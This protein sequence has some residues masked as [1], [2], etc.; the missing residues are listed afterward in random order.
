LNIYR[1]TTKQYGTVTEANIGNDV[2]NDNLVLSME[3]QSTSQVF[4]GGMNVYSNTGEATI[5]P[6]SGIYLGKKVNDTINY[7]TKSTAKG[8]LTEGIEYVAGAGYAS[9]TNYPRVRVVGQNRDTTDNTNAN[10]RQG[11]NGLDGT[12]IDGT[13]WFT[14]E[15]GIDLSLPTAGT[16]LGSYATGITAN[17][18]SGFINQFTIESVTDLLTYT[19]S[20][21]S[22]GGSS[23]GKGFIRQYTQLEVEPPIA[24]SESTPWGY[25]TA[26]ATSTLNLSKVESITVTDGGQGY[27][28][29][30]QL[31]IQHPEE[32]Y[33]EY[34]W[35]DDFDNSG[36]WI[37]G[38]IKGSN[39]QFVKAIDT[40][41]SKYP[42]EFSS[43]TFDDRV[44]F[45]NRVTAYVLNLFRAF[46]EVT[47]LDDDEIGDYAVHTK[48]PGVG[49]T[50]DSPPKVF[51]APPERIIESV[52]KAVVACPNSSGEI[53][54]I[55]VTNTGIGLGDGTDE[56]LPTV[57]IRGT[58]LGAEAVANVSNGQLSTIT[59][60]EG[61]TCYTPTDCDIDTDIQADLDDYYVL[62]IT[63]QN[64]DSENVSLWSGYSIDSSGIYT[65]RLNRY[66]GCTDGDIP[67]LCVCEV[68]DS[69]S[70]QICSKEVTI[71]DTG[72][73]I[74]TTDT[75]NVDWQDGDTVY[76]RNVVSVD[77]TPDVITSGIIGTVV[78]PLSE[79]FDGYVRVRLSVSDSLLLPGDTIYRN[80]DEATQDAITSVTEAYPFVVG[81]RVYQEP[82]L[83]VANQSALVG[84]VDQA[85][86]GTGRII[87]Y[88]FGS[89]WNE[90]SAFIGKST[91]ALGE[92]T[93]TNQ[94]D[95]IS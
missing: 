8:S 89:A 50:V 45:R 1:V 64:E 4:F 80:G 3:G 25:K 42:S 54:K 48:F 34:A 94:L 87:L 62:T 38:S 27:T 67:V 52:A 95:L 11:V 77:C 6:D 30:P 66:G 91:N 2:C 18:L 57:D 55:R 16:S 71:A 70:L 83:S 49:Y 35:E 36:E 84:Y 65:R 60:T 82:T 17:A 44:D 40:I 15:S 58:G 51:I 81:E 68:N 47:E 24:Y 12:S 78:N 92:G 23:A 14:G 69:T 73:V 29:D 20:T 39:Q 56:E 31:Y 22:Y 37:G 59:I 33:Y 19:K 61:G 53:S 72:T 75:D 28:Y 13:I 85:A 86:D 7:R 46:A 26:T 74:I 5:I 63:A 9:G 76:Y 10:N 79:S 32:T 43:W 21:N 93:H 90:S 41:L 88:D